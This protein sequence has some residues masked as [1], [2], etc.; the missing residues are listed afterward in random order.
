M[1]AFINPHVIKCRFSDVPICEEAAEHGYEKCNKT[2]VKQCR[3]L[4]TDSDM[5]AALFRG[6]NA[7]DTVFREQIHVE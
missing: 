1:H 3:A 2:T 5:L 4:S 7:S 6:T